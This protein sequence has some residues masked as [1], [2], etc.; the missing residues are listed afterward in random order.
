MRWKEYVH[1]SEEWELVFF[2]GERFKRRMDG[3][4][5]STVVVFSFRFF[6]LEW[7]GMDGWLYI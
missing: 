5:N 6:F 1:I 3:S 2:G 7:D 4:F